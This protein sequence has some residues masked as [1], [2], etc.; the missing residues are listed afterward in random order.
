MIEVRGSQASVRR[1]YNFFSYF[2]GLTV[3]RLERR[4][5]AYGLAKARAAPGER[6]LEVAVGPGGTFKKLREQVGD[7][8]LAVGLDFAPRMLA[9][10]RWRVRLANLVQ[11][12]ALHLPFAGGSFDLLWSSYF[13]DLI[14]TEQLTTVLQEFHRVLRSGG[15]LLVVNSTKAGEA[16]T[17]LERIYIHMPPALVPYLLGSC[18]PIRIEPFLRETNFTSIEREFM[19]GAMP[20]E[21]VLARR[22]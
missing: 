3:S 19:S 10:T 12:D 1:A 16:L 11:T 7:K 20:A 4:S 14:P 6:V 18:R 8:G 9:A 21:V 2:Y 13:L 22:S 17:V 5:I 15:R